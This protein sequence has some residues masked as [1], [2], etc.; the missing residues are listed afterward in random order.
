[1]M[2]KKK[3]LFLLANSNPSGQTMNV[4]E[5]W[6]LSVAMLNKA[7]QNS[8]K[9]RLVNVEFWQCSFP[10]SFDAKTLTIV[11]VLTAMSW[12]PHDGHGSNQ[13][14]IKF[15]HRFDGNPTQDVI[16]RPF[17]GSTQNS[18]GE[19][20]ASSL[21]ETSMLS[22]VGRGSVGACVGGRV[23]GKDGIRAGDSNRVGDSIDIAVGGTLN[24]WG[25]DVGGN[26]LGCA[27]KQFEQLLQ[28]TVAPMPSWLD[29]PRAS[30]MKKSTWNAIGDGVL[31]STSKVNCNEGAEW[32]L[33]V[34]RALELG[35]AC[36]LNLQP[37]RSIHLIFYTGCVC[38]SPNV[39]EMLPAT[40][41]KG[42]WLTD[43]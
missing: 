4:L 9:R 35:C 6:M 40:S 10:A 39:V 41:R 26:R 18:W 24:G 7:G 38:L 30:D 42:A 22:S 8:L 31:V 21:A 16:W 1:M 15:R 20:S 32:D 43:P 36:K 2:M 11:E 19:Q 29:V 23:G 34:S 27:R 37:V 33:F 28:S 12:C 5:L 25:G 3:N 14:P 13:E 17:D